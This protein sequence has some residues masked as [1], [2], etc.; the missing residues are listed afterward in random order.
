MSKTKNMTKK[1]YPEC[2]WDLLKGVK[3]VSEVKDLLPKYWVTALRKPA[4]EKV[5]SFMCFVN[6]NYFQDY[7]FGGWCYSFKDE[8]IDWREMT[9]EE[10]E[11]YLSDIG[12]NN[13]EEITEEAEMP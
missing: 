2:R 10:V 3:G 5:E 13:K 7:W 4:Y 9:D 11:Q 12:Y 1:E 8:V 6:G